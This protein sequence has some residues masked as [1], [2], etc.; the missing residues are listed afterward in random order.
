VAAPIARIIVAPITDVD[1]VFSLIAVSPL[2]GR[3]EFAPADDFRARN[4][5][6]GIPRAT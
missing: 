3:L 6:Y 5:E 2:F 4:L 1:V